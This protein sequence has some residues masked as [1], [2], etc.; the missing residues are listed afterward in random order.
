MRKVM[1]ATPTYDGRVDVRYT[2]A[3]VVTLKTCPPGLAIFP[4]FQP[5]DAIIQKA[6][7]ELSRIAVEQKVDDIVFIDSD[8]FW[9][10]QSF[11]RLLSHNV[12]IVGGMVRLKDVGRISVAY[13]PKAGE[14]VAENGLLEVESIGTAFTRISH[15]AIQKMW[16]CSKPYHVTMDGPE[17]REI[18]AVTIGE[19]GILC[20]EDISMCYKWTTIGGKI[21]V[22]TM[23]KCDHIGTAIYRVD[24]RQEEIK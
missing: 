21:F 6:R 23:I 15:D 14:S 4:V 7:N 9:N 2:D 8:T 1:I 17:V 12:D 11:Y 13:K 18:F 3:L 20:G 24:I 19:D 5:Y 10:P 16:D 22:D